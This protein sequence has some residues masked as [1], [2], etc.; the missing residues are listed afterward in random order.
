MIGNGDR[1]ED[2]KRRTDVGIH[3]NWP[4][5]LLAFVCEY[6]DSTLGMGYGTT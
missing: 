2:R 3:I 5:V 1:Y 4:L 6:I